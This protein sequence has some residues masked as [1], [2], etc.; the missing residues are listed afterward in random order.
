MPSPSPFFGH[1]DVS[2]L[3]RLVFAAEKHKQ[4]RAAL[5][6]IDAIPWS[7]LDAQLADS[8]ADGPHVPGIAKREPPHASCNLRLGRGIAERAKPCREKFRLANLNHARL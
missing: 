4:N 2:G 6:V 7:V 1:R 8:S 5:H 3:R